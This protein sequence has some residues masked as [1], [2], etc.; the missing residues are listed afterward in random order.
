MQQPRLVISG[1]SGG[2]GKT[3]VSLGLSRLFTRRGLSVQPCKKGPD[4]I[5][6]AWLS[7]AAGK[8]AACL[9]P[10][11]LNDEALERQFC[12]VCARRRPDIA[13]IEGNRGLFDG[14]DLQGSCSTAHVARL[15]K[16]PVVLTMNCAKMTR[17]AAA[18]VSGMANFEKDLHLAGVILNNVAGERHGSMLRRAIESYTDIPVLGI[19]PRLGSNPLPERHM[20]LSLNTTD[21]SLHAVLDKLADT[22]EEHTDA[23]VF[24]S[25]ARTAPPIPDI[26]EDDA[27][28]TV[29][30]ERPRIGYV[31][32]RAMWFYYEENLEALRDAGADLVRLDLFDDAPWPQIDGL[33]L[34][35]GYPE[36]FADAIS[37]SSH[38][39][40]IRALS[41]ANRPI[42]AECGGFMLLCRSLL[43]DDGEHPMAGL[44]PAQPRFYRRPQGLGYV[45]ARVVAE[46]PFHPLG[47]VWRGHE[48]HYSRCEWPDNRRPSCCLTLSPGTGMYEEHGTHCDGLLVR[49]TFACWTHLFA[50]AVPHWAKNFV[51]ECR[52]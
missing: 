27:P 23:G 43:L 24:L 22:L 1:L 34:G 16:A 35:G 6:Y 14:R 9:D 10:Y 47:R 29:P 17:T 39:A 31:Q 37:A 13:V 36:L 52:K 5:D 20:G 32:D 48:F 51:E 12:C 2:S 50:P 8:P 28:V 3:L 49:R 21:T 40:D 25:L 46:N 42:Y 44:L 41:L 4:Y 18:I 7:L 45:T 26:S 38:L 15:L 19:L 11:F 30:A 33:Y